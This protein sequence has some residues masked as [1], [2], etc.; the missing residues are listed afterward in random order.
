MTKFFAVLS[1]LGISLVACPLEAQCDLQGVSEPHRAVLTLEDEPGVWFVSPLA[2][3]LL[4]DVELLRSRNEE[5]QLLEGQLQLFRERSET[6][7]LLLTST[8]QQVESLTTAL[9]R[10]T[11]R[12]VAAEAW[13]LSPYLW[14]TIGVVL[15][16]AS[17]IMISLAI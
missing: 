10:M 16:V 12:A 1:S 4:R 15:G 3:C 6:A 9:E 13:W 17:V 2:R 8:E 11:E 7:D 5:V 14:T